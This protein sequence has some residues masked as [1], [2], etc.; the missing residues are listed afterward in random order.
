[1]MSQKRHLCSRVIVLLLVFTLI[2]PLVVACDDDDDESTV[3]VT[4]T[5]TATA[6]A[7]TTAKPTTPTTTTTESFLKT[8]KT[9]VFTNNGNDF[10]NIQIRNQQT[11]KDMQTLV[12]LVETP[13]QATSH[14][15]AAE[16]DP[17]V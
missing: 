5:A 14:S 15:H 1:M 13:L 7:T 6:S 8:E 3:T 12:D 2:V 9:T 10:V 11:I 4:Q 16:L 17:F